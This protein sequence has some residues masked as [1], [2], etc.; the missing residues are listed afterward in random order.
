MNRLDVTIEQ[1]LECLGCPATTLGYDRLP[2]GWIAEA[3][4][5]ES[6]ETIRVVLCFKCRHLTTPYDGEPRRVTCCWPGIEWRIEWR[7][8]EVLEVSLYDSL[9]PALYTVKRGE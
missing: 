5:T 1:P 7:E 2:R 4:T 9:I 3:W 8:S 6:G